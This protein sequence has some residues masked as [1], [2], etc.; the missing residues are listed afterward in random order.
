MLS[1][2]VAEIR[3]GERE[4]ADRST[5]TAD[6]ILGEEWGEKQNCKQKRQERMVAPMKGGQTQ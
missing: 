4:M 2:D 1:G 5:R 3:A 6:I